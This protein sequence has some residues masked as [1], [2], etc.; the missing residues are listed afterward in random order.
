M[1]N[2]SDTSVIILETTSVIIL[3]ISVSFDFVETVDRSHSQRNSY[4]YWGRK[5]NNM[6]ITDGM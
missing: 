1:I 6:D 2:N 4:Y 5:S 3:E